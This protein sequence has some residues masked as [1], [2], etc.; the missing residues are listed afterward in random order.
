MSLQ[1][2]D[3]T[4]AIIKERD[5]VTKGA[6]GAVSELV[7]QT[8]LA[9]LYIVFL[10][11]NLL[12]N[13]GDMSDGDRLALRAALAPH[14]PQIQSSLA[15]IESL[16]SIHNDDKATWQANFDTYLATN[17]TVLNEA[18]NRFPKVD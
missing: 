17:P 16:L 7:N 1:Q 9:R 2:T 3:R 15:E 8:A 12:N 4:N 10:H 6:A 14:H 13:K 18:L 11:D 5:S